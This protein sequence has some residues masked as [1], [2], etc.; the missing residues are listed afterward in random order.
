MKDSELS[1]ANGELREANS[2]ALRIRRHFNFSLLGLV[3]LAIPIGYLVAYG[4][5]GFRLAVGLI[6]EWVHEVGRAS[7]GLSQMLLLAAGGL[8]FG[9]L[10]KFLGWER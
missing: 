10:L 1:R 7:T 3:L 2:L 8:L 4:S 9:L 6:S 5:Y